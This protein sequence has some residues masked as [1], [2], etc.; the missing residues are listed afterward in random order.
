MRPKSEP[1]YPQRELFQ[2]E[3]EQ[4]IDTRHPLVQ[5]GKCIN[6][7]SFEEALRASYIP[8]TG[9]LKCPPGC[10]WRCTI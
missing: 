3:L 5:L 9:R 7:A 6:W 10:W 1:R 8:R 4:I 2:A